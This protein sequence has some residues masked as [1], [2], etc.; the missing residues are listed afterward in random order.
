MHTGTIVTTTPS[1]V[2]RPLHN[3]M[4]VV[5]DDEDVDLWLDPEIMDRTELQMLLRPRPDDVLYAYPVS[6]LVNNPCD[7]GPTLAG[8][9]AES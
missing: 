7:E 2:M 4:P 9:L 6:R 8:P 5:L 1:E 3:R